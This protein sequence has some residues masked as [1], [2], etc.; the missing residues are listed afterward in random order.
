MERNTEQLRTQLNADESPDKENYGEANMIINESIPETPFRLVGNSAERKYFIT[1]GKYKVTTD[2]DSMT[3]ALMEVENQTWELICN[4][5]AA[6]VEMMT[7]VN[8]R[9]QD[10]E[11]LKS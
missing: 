9:K 6:M 7:E 11:K 2:K 8:N 3:E 1:W 4:V 10:A 5:M